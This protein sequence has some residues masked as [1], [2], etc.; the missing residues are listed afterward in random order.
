MVVEGIVKLRPLYAARRRV[1][2]AALRPLP[3]KREERERGTPVLQWMGDGDVGGG[4]CSRATHTR[5]GWW[6]GERKGG[7][8]GTAA[9]LAHLRPAK[10]GERRGKW[11]KW[12]RRSEERLV[13]HGFEKWTCRGGDRPG[14]SGGRSWWREKRELV[15]LG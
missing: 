14:L 1:P 12:I 13:V 8:A 9:T 15:E 10:V 2:G 11:T 3:S 7:L 4:T 6:L 5:G